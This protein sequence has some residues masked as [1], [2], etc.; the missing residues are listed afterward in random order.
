MT[1]FVNV[2]MSSDVVKGYDH[3][4]WPL[5][6]FPVH[7]TNGFAGKSCCS[8]TLN[9]ILHIPSHIKYVVPMQFGS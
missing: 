5:C 3:Y 9:R 1:R 7:L 4:D 6:Y 8:Q 2:V